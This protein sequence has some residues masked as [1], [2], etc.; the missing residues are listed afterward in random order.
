MLQSITY[1]LPAFITKQAYLL[2]SQLTYS[3]CLLQFTVVLGL[4]QAVVMGT[5]FLW[6]TTIFYLQGYLLLCFIPTETYTK[7]RVI[8]S[9]KYVRDLSSEFYLAYLSIG[10]N[11]YVYNL[12]PTPIFIPF[13]TSRNAL[14][15]LSLNWH[16][17]KGNS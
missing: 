8:V 14:F 2:C 6:Q 1:K 11:W 15:V 4:V 9:T 12:V 5:F 10:C 7:I 3:C 13:L 16:C 17:V